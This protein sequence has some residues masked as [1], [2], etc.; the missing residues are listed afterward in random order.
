[1]E[2]IEGYTWHYQQDYGRMQ[3]VSEEIH[4]L[5]KYVGDYSIWGK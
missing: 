1:M 3:L 4:K 5:I 2:K